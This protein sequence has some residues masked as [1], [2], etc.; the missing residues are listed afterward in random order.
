MLAKSILIVG[1][2]I[3]MWAAFWFVLDHK[4]KAP[5]YMMLIAIILMLLG[6]II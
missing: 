5:G 2:I 1:A 3:G 4:T 6:G